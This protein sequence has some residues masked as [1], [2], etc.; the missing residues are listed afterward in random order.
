PSPSR[1]ARMNGPGSVESIG[2][3]CAGPKPPAPSPRR[4]SNV[5]EPSRL[6]LSTTT[7]SRRPSPSKSAA[8]TLTGNTFGVVVGTTDGAAIVRKCGEV[9]VDGSMW[10]TLTSL[11]PSAAMI[12]ATP[13]PSKSPAAPRGGGT[14]GGDGCWYSS[15]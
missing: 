5:P 13:S 2:N 11:V 12:S 10:Y 4:T 7:R 15:A 8:T 3:D 6:L 1:S 14:G 9:C